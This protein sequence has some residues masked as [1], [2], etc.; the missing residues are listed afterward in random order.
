MSESG[1]W[2]QRPD[3]DLAKRLNRKHG[4]FRAVN[5]AKV[6]DVSSSEVRTAAKVSL[7]FV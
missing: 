1:Y 2:P 5:Q 6:F 3:R 4:M 7:L